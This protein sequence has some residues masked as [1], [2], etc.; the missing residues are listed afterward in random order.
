MRKLLRHGT[1]GIGV[2]ALALAATNLSAQ[3]A[4]TNAPD[5]AAELAKKLSNP[6]AALISVPFQNNFE[7]RGGPNHR[8][9][10]YTLNFNPSFQ[11]R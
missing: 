4:S 2:A 5:D 6:V 1:W 7:F 9:F 11:C 8:G 3:D 10:R